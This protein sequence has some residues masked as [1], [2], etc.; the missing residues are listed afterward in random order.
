MHERP[1]VTREDFPFS[2]AQGVFYR[3]VDTAYRDLLLAGSRQA[4]R[5]S[6]PDQPTLYLSSSREG[7]AAAMIAHAD[8]RTSALEVVELSVAASDI[9]D[10]RDPDAIHAAGIDLADAVAPWQEIAKAG[11]TPSSWRVRDR[12]E[13]VGATGLIDPSRKRPGLWHLT[14]FRWNEPGAPTVTIRE[15]SAGTELSC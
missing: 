11:G 1:T 4:G 9:V 7:V 2:L 5:Y 3:A 8:S 12:L 10:L 6:R 14:L 15:S 13:A